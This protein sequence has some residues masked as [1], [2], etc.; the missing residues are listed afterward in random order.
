MIKAQKVAAV[1]CLGVSEKY[2]DELI[3]KKASF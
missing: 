2:T 1:K 3:K